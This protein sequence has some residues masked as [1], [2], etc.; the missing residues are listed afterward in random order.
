[1]NDS[2]PPGRVPPLKSEF[3]QLSNSDS[4]RAFD[5]IYLEFILRRVVH[6]LGNSIYGINSL[7]DY[8]LRSGIDDSGLRENL[9]LIRDSAEHSRHLLAMVGDLVQPAET[10]E[11]PVS[12]AELVQEASKI[13][14]MLLPR[15]V[16]LEI[17][18][19]EDDGSTCISVVRGE[20]LRKIVA[21]AAM[22]INHL[23]IASGKICMGWDR[24]E[25]RIRIFYRSVFNSPSDLRRHASTLME[26]VSRDVEVSSSGEGE[27][28]TISLSFP[29]VD[30]NESG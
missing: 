16:R 29:S 21:L 1:V 8:H 15:S 27:E 24:Q 23:R 4:L 3:N 19:S 14:K 5:R 22:D 26:H 30:P 11:E 10:A 25:S 7:S 20:F 9:E 6:D 2:H 18:E 12:P 13:F 17:A 28:F